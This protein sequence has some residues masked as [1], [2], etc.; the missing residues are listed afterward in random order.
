MA[1]LPILEEYPD[2]KQEAYVAAYDFDNCWT[3][4]NRDLEI[5]SLD[6]SAAIIRTEGDLAAT[7]SLLGRTRRQ[8]AGF[9]QRNRQIR[10]LK[11]DLEETFIDKVEAKYKQ[12]ALDGDTAALRH[13][14]QTRGRERGYGNQLA[15]AG[16][17]ENPIALTQIERSIVKVGDADSGSVPPAIESGEV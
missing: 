2:L 13:I 10:L 11:E 15:L 4:R 9:I 5:S 16:D 3:R 1:E 7:A 17:K 14:L 8:V 12:I 6:V